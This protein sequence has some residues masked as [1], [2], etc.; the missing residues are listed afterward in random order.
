MP[1]TDPQQL[2]HQLAV[3][4]PAYVTALV[5]EFR[6]SDDATTVAVVALFAPG[7]DD[8]LRRARGLAQTTR[9]RQIVTIAAA[10]LRGAHELV[11][12][13]ARDHLTDHPD[14]VVVAW[15]AARPHPSPT[16]QGVNDAGS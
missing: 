11:N 10:H 3:G 5:E 12:A 9:E 15:I 4:E 6:S 1:T 13:L 8:L 2:L 7:A 14:S 16:T